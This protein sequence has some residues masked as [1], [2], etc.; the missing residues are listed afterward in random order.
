MNI[1]VCG[2]GGGGGGVIVGGVRRWHSNFFF[3]MFLFSLYQYI[4]S[5]IFEKLNT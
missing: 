1:S 4:D 5:S 3:N 2:G